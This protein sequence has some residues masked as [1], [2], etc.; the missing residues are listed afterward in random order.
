MPYSHRG[1][2]QHLQGRNYEEGQDLLHLRRERNIFWVRFN[3][4]IYVVLEQEKN[5]AIRVTIS[6]LQGGIRATHLHI[7]TAVL[8]FSSRGLNVVSM[9]QSRSAVHL[10]RPRRYGPSSSPQTKYVRRRT[11]IGHS[12]FFCLLS[13]STIHSNSK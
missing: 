4:G 9:S 13:F 12:P 5:Q 8:V 2:H 6:R 7:A 3:G 11:T 10:G 1:N